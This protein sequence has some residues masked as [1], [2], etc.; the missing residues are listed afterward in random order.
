MLYK[1]EILILVYV[2]QKLNFKKE[3]SYEVQFRKF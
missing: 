1:Y 2:Q 3:N